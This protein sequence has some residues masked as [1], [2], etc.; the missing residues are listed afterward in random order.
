MKIKSNS[1][2]LIVYLKWGCQYIISY[3]TVFEVCILIHSDTFL[4]LFSSTCM[5]NIFP[6]TFFSFST[7]GITHLLIISSPWSLSRPCMSTSHLLCL[8]LSVSV[9]AGIRILAPLEST[10]LAGSDEHLCICYR[11][12]VIQGIRVYIL[13]NGNI[14]QLNLIQVDFQISN[15]FYCFKNNVS[16]I[17]EIPWSGGLDK[18]NEIRVNLC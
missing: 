14:S 6:I 5:L 18:C 7:L 3:I 13:V 15:L 1:L 12:Q 17:F 9:W 11:P 4:C 16:Y 2:L 8:H 10:S